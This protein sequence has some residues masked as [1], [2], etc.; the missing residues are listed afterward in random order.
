MSKT[1]LDFIFK[2]KY[3]MVIMMVKA[4]VKVMIKSNSS[5][6]AYKI[7]SGECECRDFQTLMQGR[8]RCSDRRD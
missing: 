1:D 7:R 4:M 5:S 2:K 8:G 6:L 3:A